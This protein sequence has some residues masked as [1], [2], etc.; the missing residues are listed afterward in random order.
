M[1]TATLKHTHK[2]RSLHIGS[3][4]VLPLAP[5]LLFLIVLF[6][7][8]VVL[9][10]SQSVITPEGTWSTHNFVRL[11]SSSSYLK[12]LSLTLKISFWTALISVGL[13]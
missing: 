13:S 10:L 8:P 4:Y 7:V 5:V 3:A 11:L 2:A 1:T 9:L 12:S 6:I